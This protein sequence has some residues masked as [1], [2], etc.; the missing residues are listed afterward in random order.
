MTD[1]HLLIILVTALS[2]AALL[3]R[4]RHNRRCMQIVRAYA[5]LDLCHNGRSPEESRLTVAS[6]DRRTCLDLLDHAECYAKARFDG[7]LD[8]MIACAHQQGLND[9]H[10]RH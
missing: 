10:A 2:A 9:Q 6:L 7:D 3:Y 5:F 4:Y 8:A 1:L